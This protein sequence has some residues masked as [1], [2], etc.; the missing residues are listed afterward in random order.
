MRDGCGRGSLRVLFVSR[1]L[2]DERDAFR[3]GF[4]V[5]T[6]SEMQAVTSRKDAKRPVEVLLLDFEEG[7][8]PAERKAKKPVNRLSSA[9]IEHRIVNIPAPRFNAPALT[10]LAWALESVWGA[11]VVTAVARKERADLIHTHGEWATFTSIAASKILR[12]PLV[13]ETHGIVEELFQPGQGLGIGYRAAKLFER[14]C[15]R[16]SRYLI[17]VSEAMR[18]HFAR[19]SAVRA[20][21]VPCSVDPLLLEQDE[22]AGPEA[23]RELMLADRFVVAY[24]GSFFTH[25]QQPEKLAEV[26]KEIKERIANSV[27]LVLTTDEVASVRDFLVREGLGETDF[28]I[29]RVAHADV[30]RY[31]VAADA[32]LLIRARDLV[33][34]VA[35]PVKFGEYLACGVPVLCTEGIGDISGIV[36]DHAVGLVIDNEVERVDWDLTCEELTKLT[37][38]GT[39]QRCRRIAKDMFSW[40]SNSALIVDLYLELVEA[41]QSR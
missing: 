34:Q 28:H 17:V 7:G 23:R 15:I 13:Y 1:G 19:S 4:Q 21:V 25:W 32:G 5:R 20:K 31:L 41:A 27:F 3:T 29:R 10:Y 40:E 14:I 36:R 38:P 39:K 26:F 6:F 22:R 2:F 37:D 35:C 24:S 18:A 8:Y 33:N 9:G 11:C 30:P 12:L 16:N